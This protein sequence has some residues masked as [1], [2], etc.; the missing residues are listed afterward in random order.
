MTH[1]RFTARAW[2]HLQ[3]RF[4]VGMALALLESASASGGEGVN[5][6]LYG[7]P[8]PPGAVARLGT[9]RLRHFGAAVAFSKDGK[10]LISCDRYGEVHVWDTATG[11][12]LREKR[13]SWGRPEAKGMKIIALSPDGTTAAGLDGQVAYVCDTN[14]GKERGRIPSVTGRPY[15]DL[16]TFS[17]DG[18]LLAVQTPDE[19]GRTV[20]VIWDVATVKKC[21]TLKNPSGVAL[22]SIAFT[23]DGKQLAGIT[24]KEHVH[25]NLFLWDLATGKLICTR[26]N[27][28]QMDT[29]SLAFSPDGKTLVVGGHE[30]HVVRLLDAGTLKE[31]AQLKPPANVLPDTIHRLAFAPDGRHLA[32]SYSLDSIWGP[33]E[34][35][36]L[37]WDLDG[38]RR[39]RRLPERSTNYSL[40]LAFAPNG[41]MLVGYGGSH[42]EFRLWDVTSGD[43]VHCCPGHDSA[44]TVLAASPDGKIVAS[45]T[46]YDGDTRL[47]LWDAATGKQLHVLGSRNANIDRMLIS[48]SCVF[49]PDGT[50]VVSIGWTDRH[51]TLFQVWDVATGK[52]LRLIELAE[53]KEGGCSHA[54]VISADGKRMAAVVGWENEAALPRLIVWNLG[55]GERLSQRP[56]KLEVHVPAT[57]DH[58]PNAITTAHTAF[59]PDGESVTV[60]LGDRVGIEEV[61]TGCLLAALPKG[62]GQPLLFSPDGRLVAAVWQLAEHGPPH[63]EFKGL[64]LIDSASGEEIIRLEPESFRSMAFTPDGHGL[65]VVDGE[66]LRVWDTTTGERLH[67]GK[68]PERLAKEYREWRR[69]PMVLLPGGRMATGMFLSDILVWDVAASTWP[70]RKQVRDI[71]RKD[72]DALWADLAGS[73][74]KAHRA[75][76]ILA[77][78]PDQ[79]VPFLKDRL[80]PVPVDSKQI[81]KLLADLD[82]DSFAA[83][84]T[85]SR[86]L[87]RLHYQAG[88]M[89]RQALAGKPS[90]EMRRRLQAILAG[91]KRPLPDDLRVLRAMEVLERIGTPEA[92][93]IL[94][95]FAGGG[96]TVRETREAKAALQRLNRR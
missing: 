45:S 14:T 65:L 54:P 76:A 73:A 70:A 89:L 63:K 25:F 87:S 2:R 66:R 90:L 5:T 11:R 91:P 51:T 52:E 15:R 64:S 78:A 84:E 31:K 8:L 88:P 62:V 95:T 43:L 79:A 77:A 13:L 96:K 23:W 16:L 72:L 60:W 85:A 94:E 1:P 22:S 38:T 48:I 57:S 9:I 4:V 21:Q 44:V 56:Y 47:R 67:E 74:R 41:K 80:Q 6:D 81:D 58:D 61:S 92:R 53:E 24:E 40:R 27:L 59:A 29:G 33:A 10:H 86:E 69:C 19:E 12:L 35:G 46:F 37:L 7:D 83:R 82:G 17:P 32:A 3:T 75:I 42:A 20:T 18:K 30:E 55:T 68:V 50:R 34:Y 39:A 26:E 93:R 28:R 49:S 71:G 36:V